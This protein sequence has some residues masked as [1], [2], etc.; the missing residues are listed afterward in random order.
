MRIKARYE[1]K[2]L[3]P[4]EELNLKEGEEVEIEIKKK[5]PIKKLEGLIKLTNQEWV[6]EI[7]ESPDLE[8]V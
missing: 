8:P 7:I 3:K 6:D 4:L 5:D 1:N 2:V